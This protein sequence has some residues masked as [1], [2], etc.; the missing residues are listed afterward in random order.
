M[1]T[2]DHFSNVFHKAYSHQRHK[3]KHTRRRKSNKIKCECN[4][5]Q[6]QEKGKFC[7]LLVF[8]DGEHIESMNHC[9]L[10]AASK[11]KFLNFSCPNTGFNKGVFTL[12]MKR[13]R[14]RK[15][16]HTSE[17]G[18]ASEDVVHARLFLFCGGSSL[19]FALTSTFKMKICEAR[20]NASVRCTQEKEKFPFS[21]VCVKLHSHLFNLLLLRV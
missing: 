13:K 18:D 19:R 9:N 4:L 15:D 11:L 14:K 16:I 12:E 10:R 20:A 7:L 17:A 1:P 21:C 3:R 2:T 8:R 6:T 5:M